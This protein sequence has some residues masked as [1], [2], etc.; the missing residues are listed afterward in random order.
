MK[1]DDFCEEDPNKMKYKRPCDEK[2]QIS[3]LARSRDFLKNKKRK[4]NAM[5]KGLVD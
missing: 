3:L 2:F 1:A 4:K 5:T